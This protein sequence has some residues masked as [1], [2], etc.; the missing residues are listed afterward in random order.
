MKGEENSIAAVVRRLD[1]MFGHRLFGVSISCLLFSTE[2]P[3]G[4]DRSCFES[5]L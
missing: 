4:L 2:S 5:T 1:I 3:L